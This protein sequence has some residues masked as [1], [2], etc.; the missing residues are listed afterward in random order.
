MFG[1]IESR[2]K[3]VLLLYLALRGGC[4]GR[5]LA[6]KL[7]ISPSQI[8]KALRYLK[9][10]K[11]IIQFVSPTFYALNPRHPCYFELASILDKAYRAHPLR[12]PFLPPIAPDRKVDPKSVYEI[13]ALRGQTTSFEKLS[14]VL[15]RKYA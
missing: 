9:K 10:H 14:D 7:R 3:S 12:Y 15:R 1:L 13:I 4:S 2:T 5:G 11:V 6:R 8:F